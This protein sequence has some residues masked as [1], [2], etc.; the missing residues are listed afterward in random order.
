MNAAMSPTTAQWVSSWSLGFSERM[1]AA[2]SIRVG[3]AMR[4]IVGGHPVAPSRHPSACLDLCRDRAEADPEWPLDGWIG[5]SRP[6]TAGLRDEIV[7]VGRDLDR[8]INVGAKKLCPAVDEAPDR[9]RRRMAVGIAP[10]GADHRDP[11]VEPLHES[12]R[13]RRSAAVMS[14]LEHVER[15]RQ[16]V[17]DARRDQLRVD[18]LLDVTA[19]QHPSLAE[20]QVKHDRDVVDLGA[21]IG[22]SQWNAPAERATPR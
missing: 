15:R 3:I 2:A 19:E 20:G 10:A 4:P 7:A 22:R 21:R 1:I 11:R 14:D 5:R 13:G 16:L 8:A 17:R 6:A 12:I 18:L 9:L